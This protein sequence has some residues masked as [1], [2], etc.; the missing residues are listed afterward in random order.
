M[1]LLF[2]DMDQTQLHYLAR[3]PKR[4][5]LTDSYLNLHAHAGWLWI[6]EQSQGQKHPK[7]VLSSCSDHSFPTRAFIDSSKQPR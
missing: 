4:V 1:L 5:G 6:V 7:P 2:F 3:L